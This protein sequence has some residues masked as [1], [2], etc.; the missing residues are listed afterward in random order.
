MKGGTL[1]MAS[2]VNAVVFDETGTLAVNRPTISDFVMMD[3]HSMDR[4]ALLWL[5]ASLERTSEHPLATAVV[6]YAL[7]ELGD[8]YLTEKPLTSPI[9]F[10]ARQ[11][12]ELW[13]RLTIIQWQLAIAHL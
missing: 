7:D 12:E 3:S 9:D 10:V 4:D 1:E 5:F 2:K 13:V 6:A 11:V 8:T